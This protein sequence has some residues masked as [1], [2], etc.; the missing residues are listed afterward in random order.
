MT[1]DMP[2]VN[3]YYIALSVVCFVLGIAVGSIKKFRKPEERK[4]EE[5]PE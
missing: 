3:V 2:L 1:G 4:K 5:K